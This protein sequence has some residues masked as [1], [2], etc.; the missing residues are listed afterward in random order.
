MHF[1]YHSPLLF[2]LFDSI[3]KT[4]ETLHFSLH[5]FIYLQI[6]EAKTKVLK[7]KLRHVLTKTETLLL[8]QKF[9]IFL[10]T[11]LVFKKTLRSGR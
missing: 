6:R 1:K 3:L 4:S 11:K 10:D 8:K 9:L 7:N 2:D 5:F